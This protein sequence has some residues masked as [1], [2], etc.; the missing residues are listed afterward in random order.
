MYM[1]TPE[2][3]ILAMLFF[4]HNCIYF[5]PRAYKCVFLYSPET[6]AATIT[7]QQKAIII[8][9]IIHV[10]YSKSDLHAWLSS[11]LPTKLAF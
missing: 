10:R 4:V 1:H 11:T 2:A 9:I 7:K 8:I 3:H 6:A 5:N